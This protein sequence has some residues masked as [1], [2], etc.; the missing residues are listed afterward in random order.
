MKTL[1]QSVLLFLAL[2]LLAAEK[3]APP[4][5]PPAEIVFREL[6]YDGKVS[7]TEAR[8]AVEIAVEATGKGEASAVL[9]DGEIALLPPKLP[10]GLRVEREG[11]V[12]RLFIPRAGKYQL[13]LEVVAKITRAEPWN[14]VSFRGPLAAIASVSAQA[15]GA[16]IDLQ[17]LAGTVAEATQANGVSRVR[18][19]LGAES[20]LSLRWQ[21]RAAEVTRKAVVAAESTIAA[22]I[23]PTVIKYS[24]QF[25]YDVIQGKLPKLTIAL[26]TAHA[27]TRLVGDQIRDWSLATEGDKQILT[28]EFI[29]AIEKTY[30]LTVLSE[31][32]VETTPATVS[33]APPQPLDAERESGAFTLAAEDMQAEIESA[34]GLRQVNAT[35]G[36]F[37]AY[38][39]SARPLAL[40]LRLKRIESVVT[41]SDRV[42]TRLEETRLLAN[43]ALTLNVEKAGIYQIELQPQ[44][45]FVVA[46][47]RG[48]GVDD[49][50]MAEGKLRVSFANRVLGARRIEVQ[51]EQALKN[52]PE[53]FAIEPLRVVGATKETAQVGAASAAG[54][55]LKTA[56]LVGLREIPVNRLA[57]RADELLAFTADAAEWKLTLSAER[58]SARVIAEIF[59]LVTVGD[60]LV[61]GS[62][63]IRYGLINQGVQEFRVKVPAHWKN[64]E[65]TGPSIRRKEQSG[66]V[67]TI[68]LQDKA[69]GAY[70]LVVTYDYQFDPQGATLPVAGIHALDVEQETG[71]VAV[72]TAASLKLNAK[73]VAE[74]LR[75]VDEAEL[76]SADRA[77]ITRSVL[78][79]YQYTGNTYD[80]SVDVKRY[81]ASAVLSA[82]A[83][84]TQLTSVLTEAGELLTQAS[85]MVKNNDKQ[86]QRFLLPTNAS[87]WS[88]YVNGQPAKPERDKDWLL[89][90]LPRGAN[91]DQAFAVDIVYAEKKAALQS[92]SQ[93]LALHAPQTDVP[94]TYAEWQLFVPTAKRLSSFGGSMNVAQGTD[95][96]VLDAWKQFLSFYGKVLREIGPGLIIFGLLAVLVVALVVIAA[97]RGASGLLTALVVLAIMAILGAM[98][99]PALSKAKSKA[100]RISSVNNLKQVGLAV[101]IF[102]GDNDDR[103]PVSFEEMMNELSTDKVTYDVESGQR[104]TYLGAGYRDGEITTDSII[105]Y[106]PVVN[107]HCNVLMADGSVQMLSERKFSEYAQRGFIQRVPAAALARVEQER[108]IRSRQLGDRLEVPASA[109]APARLGAAGVVTVTDGMGGGGGNLGAVITGSSGVPA[110]TPVVAAMAPPPAKAAGLRSIRIDIPRTG[111]AFLFAKVLNVRDEPLSVSASI[112]SLQTF[113]QRQMMAQVAAFLT[114]LVVWFWQWRGSRNSFVLTLAL[115]LMFGSVASLLIAWRALHDVLIV[116]FPIIL[117]MV[118]SWL[119]WKFWARRTKNEAAAEVSRDP[120]E[121]GAPEIPPAVAGLVVAALLALPLS[122]QATSVTL[123]PVPVPTNV[124]VLSATYTGSV[125][126][127]VAQLDAIVRVNAAQANQKI[128]LFGEDVAVQSFSAKP[129]DAKIVREGKTVSV[130]LPRK[131]EV[132]LQLKL[133]VRLSGDV[134]KRQLAF[135]IPAALTTRLNL[136]IDQPDADVEF[137]GAISFQR[138]TEAQQTRLDALM[139]SGDR[140]T[141]AWTP[142]VKRAAEV[143][144]TVMCQN[145][146][147]VSFGGGVMS[148][149]SVLDYQVTQGELRSVRVKLPAG[150]RL[151]RVEGDSIRTWTTK[152]EGGAQ[153]LVVDLLKGMTPNYRL[154]VETEKALEALPMTATVE[155]PHALDVKRETGLV[156]LRAEDEL[157]FSVARTDEL[158]RVDTAAFASSGAGQNA[159]GV[160][161]A[162]RFLKPEFTLEARVTALQPQIEAVVRNSLRVGDEQLSLTATIDYVIKRVGVFGLKFTVPAEYRIESVTGANVLQWNER[163]DGG[164]R[165]VEV[166]LKERTAGAYA[167]RV[168]LVKSVKSLEKEL[169]FTGVQPLGTQKLSGFVS[170]SAEPGVSVKTATFDGL[171]EIPV[172]L[173][174]GGSPRGNE[175][176]LLA[177][178]FIAA[179]SG[180]AAP[181][182]LTV[183][184]E[185]ITPWVR[186]EVAGTL[187]VSDTQVSGRAQVRFDIQNAPVKELRLK[188]PVALKNVEITGANIRRRDHTGEV[189][190]VELQNKVRGNYTLTVTWDQ[191]RGVAAERVDLAELSVEGVERETGTL[192]IVA[193]APL[194]ITEASA[195]ELLKLD[196]HEWPEWAGAAEANTALAY[197]YLRPGYKL[198]VDVK[199]YSE[200]E[201][202]QA[203]AETV[204]LSTV[205]AEDGQMMTSLS[206]AVRNNGRQHLEVVLP[207]GARVWSAFVAGQAVR[208][209]LRDGKLLLPLENAGS[210]DAALAVELTYVSTNQNQFPRGK[211]AV[212]LVSPTLDV[213]LKNARWE[214][215]LPPD[216][217]YDEFSGTMTRE[218]GV[219]MA[220]MTADLPPVNDEASFSVLDYSLRESAAK[221]EAAKGVKTELDNVKKKLAEGNVKD[222]ANYYS[223]VQ[224]RSGGRDDAEETKE[225]ELQLRRA[226]ASNIVQAQQEFLYRNN[227]MFDQST[228]MNAPVGSDQKQD[229]YFNKAAEQQWEKLQQA[230]EVAVAKVQPLRVNLP[231]RGL[232]HSF[233][234]VLQTE[235]GKAMTVSFHA[236]NTKNVN[237]LGRIAVGAVGFLALWVVVA[238]GTSRMSQRTQPA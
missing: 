176:G 128:A 43:H 188:I 147:L 138:A 123:D 227:G 27:L 99:L 235:T 78:L 184:T 53:S 65:F 107:G 83:D 69:W 82:V 161:S 190:R 77:L 2:P 98:L 226:Q 76:T 113:Q 47:V 61:G 68:G 204:H 120:D 221:Q 39:F 145:A 11:N 31:Q 165:V 194:Q 236:E 196:T 103:L 159:S 168:D 5:T 35:G 7:D 163:K 214:L 141:L 67:W 205:V 75:R 201:V 40:T 101:R 22:Q 73:A 212:S 34:S 160:T 109:A 26:P 93:T 85:F 220:T 206:V 55:Q 238:V 224:N 177:Y 48:E 216:Y 129:R 130:L 37:A 10:D 213:P 140:V 172:G 225:V 169:T 126:E 12:Y 96:A 6:R 223:R 209:S 46:D 51:L 84:R 185:T 86:F 174:P 167:L 30:Q 4:P 155:T 14:H 143:A 15:N 229:A 87:F 175:T 56:E 156:A 94:N 142:R 139:G 81:E 100:Q 187:T 181:W 114:G 104:F 192:A 16:D 144:A 110:A 180:V 197:R 203:L 127:R 137:P 115:A 91:R 121:P 72:T 66:D 195:A 45:G 202:L 135:A 133:L 193:K 148:V 125:N 1:M 89:V 105:A 219:T 63:T 233:T 152:E 198:A 44:A 79:A 117:L 136:T 171:T 215:F 146:A 186:A 210:D 71:S 102:A 17:L 111:N 217:Q 158:Q 38:R 228:A 24:T 33:L 106:S 32:T 60:G 166:T 9:F 218:A 170:V 232:R 122:A 149:R 234:Q 230:Q 153:I 92:G 19:F 132:T 18:G 13:K 28:V 208:P 207:P 80:L 119:V 183:T 199:R 231:T 134:A 52:F 150:Q 211:G 8:F 162:F 3:P 173:L 88:C 189:W 42:T 179:E 154:T 36:S 64:V 70:T 59:N 178:K 54:I 108:A 49:W 90:P 95:Y 118:V 164:E 20:Q 21:S 131:G 57:S 62:A 29:K 74:P 41:A 222:A 157:E 112:M 182:K 50:K 200:A 191:T 116:G 237:W 58:L 151:L 23:T 25:R 97:R 124:S